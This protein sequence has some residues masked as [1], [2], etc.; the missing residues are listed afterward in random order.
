MDIS[1]EFRLIESSD[2]DETW[3]NLIYI[4]ICAYFLFH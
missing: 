4:Q 2:Q 3:L 1:E